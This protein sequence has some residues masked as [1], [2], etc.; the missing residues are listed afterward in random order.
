MAH[1]PTIIG[2]KVKHPKI[3]RDVYYYNSPNLLMASCGFS[4]AKHFH[5]I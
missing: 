2:A 5:F 1:S 3:P 4:G